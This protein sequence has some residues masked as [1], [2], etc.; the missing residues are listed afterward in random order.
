VLYGTGI[1][2]VMFFTIVGIGFYTMLMEYRA[3]SMKMAQFEKLKK[4]SVSQRNT[5][6]RYEQDITQLS[7]QLSQ[8][9]QLNARLMVLTGLDPTNGENNLGLGGSAEG[10]ANLETEE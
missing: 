3:V 6:D 9:K 10:D 2:F 7:K 4:I 8:I 5:I 1:G